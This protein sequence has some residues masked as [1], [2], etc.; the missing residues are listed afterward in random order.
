MIRRQVVARGRRIRQQWRSGSGGAA[1]E[2]VGQR[3]AAVTQRA[4]EG[5]EETAEVGIAEV[6]GAA[7]ITARF[8]DAEALCPAAM[9]IA[10][11]AEAV[12]YGS[13]SAFGGPIGGI[14][15]PAEAEGV[16]VAGGV[17]QDSDDIDMEGGDGSQAERDRYR[18]IS[19]GLGRAHDALRKALET[20]AGTSCAAPAVL[21][22]GSESA[23][24]TAGGASKARASINTGAAGGN[25]HDCQVTERLTE[26]RE[27][28]SAAL[29]LEARR[30]PPASLWRF[31]CSSGGWA[32]R[33][34][35][36][37][38][39]QEEE[40]TESLQD[41]SDIPLPHKRLTFTQGDGFTDPGWVFVLV[42]TLREKAD[43][44]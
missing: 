39:G 6:A 15:A 23:V 11:A 7:A 32:E 1:P 30:L 38:G 20:A 43:D 22:S 31:R 28:T 16:A 41:V 42:R 37:G 21:S 24:A 44:L 25:G 9:T 12:L 34:G 26:G 17:G 40:D 4:K 18:N 8:A 3:T 27:G 19:E 5:D 13:T 29:S 35:K 10:R 2:A 33:E 36:G 14:G